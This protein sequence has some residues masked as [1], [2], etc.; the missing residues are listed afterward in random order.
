MKT[1][2]QKTNDVKCWNDFLQHLLMLSW[3]G[4]NSYCCGG[5][6]N[7][8]KCCPSIPCQPWS[9]SHPPNS[10]PPSAPAEGAS[11]RFRPRTLPT[12]S[13]RILIR[14]CH[15][16]NKSE[17]HRSMQFI[18]IRRSSVRYV[19]LRCCT[20]WHCKRRGRRCPQR[21]NEPPTPWARTRCAAARP[22]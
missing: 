8:T 13:P 12:R 21:P 20:D 4:L 2:Q 19:P 15:T 3:F 6:W 16:A 17:N 11:H 18:T 22:C 7:W 1:C 10:C 14:A 9:G 5:C